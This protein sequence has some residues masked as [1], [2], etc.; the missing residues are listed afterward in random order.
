MKRDAQIKSFLE[1][2]GWANATR[3]PLNGDASFRRY[4][5]LSRGNTSAILMDAPP[6]SE[7]LQAY[8]GIAQLLSKLGYSA[9]EILAKD[10]AG[11][12]AVIEDFGDDTYTRVLDSDVANED[13]LYTLA[14]DILIDIHRHPSSGQLL[15]EYDDIRFLSEVALF[16]DWYLPAI[17]GKDLPAAT[18][19]EFLELW[20]PL[21]LVAREVPDGIVLRDFHVGNLMVLKNRKGLRACGLLDFQD[22]VFGPVTYDIV[23]LLEDAR[24]DVSRELSNRLICRYLDAFA[25][26]DH[27][28]FSASYAVLG[29]QR[30]MKI[31]GIFTRLDRRDRKPNYLVH[32][33]RVWHWLRSDLT[34]PALASIDA[35]LLRELPMVERLTPHSLTTR[36]S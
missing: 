2:S 28:I 1:A 36:V 8:I 4:D 34:H 18:R 19:A 31:I 24:R 7:N 22:A 6:T 21:L 5:R 33:P 23:S 13:T 17:R 12:L 25:T 27:D 32:L 9:P 20:K 11:G 30:A 14:L 16:V 29:A 35:W 26:L 3:S 15:P 10:E